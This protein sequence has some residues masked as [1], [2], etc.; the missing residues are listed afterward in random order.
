MLEEK[1]TSIS[2]PSKDCSD[3]EFPKVVKEVGKLA[4]YDRHNLMNK[5]S[6]RFHQTVEKCLLK[7]N[8]C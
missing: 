6:Y 7:S 1:V 2:D 3:S 4:F 8:T 5:T